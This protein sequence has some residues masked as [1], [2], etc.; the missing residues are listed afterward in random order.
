LYYVS[1]ESS[2]GFRQ[3]WE[4]NVKGIDRQMDY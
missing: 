4:D 2:K 3:R 1:L